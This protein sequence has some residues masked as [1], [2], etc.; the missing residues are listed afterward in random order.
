MSK[1]NQPRLFKWILPVVALMLPLLAAACGSGVEAESL[2]PVGLRSQDAPIPVDAGAAEAAAIAEIEVDQPLAAPVVVEL[3]DPAQTSPA[4]QPAIAPVTELSAAEAQGL[5]YMREE[6]KLARDVYLALYELWGLPTFQTIAGSEQAHMDAVLSLLEQYGL[7]DP[8]AGNDAG[9]FNDP[10]FT[11]LYEQLLAQGS[12]SVADA[13]TVGAAIEELDIVD[14]QARMAETADAYVLQ[15]YGNLLAGSENHLRAF[16]NSL[17]QQTGATYQP[18]YLEQA[19]FEAMMS[20]V[21][22]RGSGNG[23]VGAGGGNGLGNGGGLGNGKGNG[24]GSG[25]GS[26]GGNGFGRQG[27]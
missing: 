25:R 5:A 22:G 13:L 23:G 24:R 7:A 9:V 18:V 16:V 2:T 4:A 27:G 15:V 1:F 20:G 11:A 19:E 21:S 10:Q 14:L 6:E 26:G 17:Q 12:L 3:S 8:A